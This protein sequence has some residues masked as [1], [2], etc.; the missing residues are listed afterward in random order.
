M[1][2]LRNNKEIIHAALFYNDCAT[3]HVKMSKRVS[4]VSCK[5]STGNDS[6]ET[7]IQVD[8]KFHRNMEI[9]MN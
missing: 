7:E 6:S 3:S 2:L 8:D 1:E 9:L 4:L 5:E